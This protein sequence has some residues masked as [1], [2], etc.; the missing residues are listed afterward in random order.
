MSHRAVI[1]AACTVLLAACGTTSPQGQA[2]G[3]TANVSDLVGA[4]GSSFNDEMQRR[5][6]VSKGGYQGGGRAMST[7][8]NPG[9]RQCLEA[10]TADGRIQA[11]NPI[12]DSNCR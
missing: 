11:I 7:W 1:V 8:Y 10:V 4:R 12:P 2:P 9:T 3:S 5:G 6:F